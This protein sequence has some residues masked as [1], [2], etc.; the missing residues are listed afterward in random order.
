MANNS[1]GDE[2][3]PHAS[4]WRIDKIMSD[5]IMYLRR[6]SEIGQRLVVIEAMILSKHD[7]VSDDARWIVTTGSDCGLMVATHEDIHG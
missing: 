4:V 3:P 7:F 1:G 5:K 6:T 2:P